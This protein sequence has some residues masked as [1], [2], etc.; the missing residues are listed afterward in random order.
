MSCND[1]R[2][3]PDRRAEGAHLVVE[4]RGADLLDGCEDVWSR[5]PV[6]EWFD[7]ELHFDRH[8]RRLTPC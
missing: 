5:F 2:V 3:A 6:D 1:T 4:S 7:G 8:G